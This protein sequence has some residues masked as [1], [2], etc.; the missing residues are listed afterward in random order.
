MKYKLVIFDFDGTLANTFPWV[1]NN[2]DQVADKFNIDRVDRDQIEDLRTFDLRKLMKHFDVP[3]WKLA[4]MARHVRT[5][6]AEDIQQVSLFEGIDQLLQY[7]SEQGAMLAVV[8]SNSYSNVRHVLGP[9][10]S[11]LIDYYECGVSV[12]GKSSKFKKILRKSGVEPTDVI[13]IG[14]EIRDIQAAKHVHIASGAVT[15]GFS[16]VDALKA[17]S[18]QEMFSRVNEIAEK[19]T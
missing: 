13:S 17:Q 2:M 18:P 10:N 9:I 12:F 16:S 15:W 8:S 11:A 1:L 19:I 3:P 5:L 7:L 6:L 4:L 14:D